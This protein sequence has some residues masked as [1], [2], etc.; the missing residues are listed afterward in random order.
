MVLV[1]PLD[2]LQ[3]AYAEL[4]Q[5]Q[6]TEIAA[7]GAMP[8]PLVI[9]VSPEPDSVATAKMLTGL[10]CSDDIRYVLKAVATHQQLK[11]TVRDVIDKDENVS[12]Q[13]TRGQTRTHAKA[14]ECI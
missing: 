5:R 12:T 7:T 6:Q 10:L 8:A 14:M 4:R 11:D 3:T 2:S 1:Q 13:H 9:L